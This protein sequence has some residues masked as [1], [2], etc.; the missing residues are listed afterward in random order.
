[1]STD[2]VGKP[3]GKSS[4]HAANRDTQGVIAGLSCDGMGLDPAPADTDVATGGK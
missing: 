1:M 2:M 3:A 4:S